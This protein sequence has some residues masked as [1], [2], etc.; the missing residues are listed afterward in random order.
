MNLAIVIV[1]LDDDIQYGSLP[2][3]NYRLFIRN[4]KLT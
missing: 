4:K 3:L 1:T 2:T